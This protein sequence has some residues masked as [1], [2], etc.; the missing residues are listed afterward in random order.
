MQRP[1]LGLSLPCKFHRCIDG[2]TIEIQFPGSERV[3]KIRLIDCWCPELDTPKGKEAKQ[4]AEKIMKGCMNPVVYIP[5]PRDIYN[6]L[7]NLTFDRILGYI[8]V[9]EAMT[10]NEIIVLAGHGTKTKKG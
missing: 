5:I 4:Y 8:F 6:L 7:G 2:D 10:L 1:D 3:W 9:G